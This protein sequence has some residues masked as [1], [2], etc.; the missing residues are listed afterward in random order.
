MARKPNAQSS[1]AEQELNKVEEQFE[2]FDEDVKELTLDRMRAAPKE[3]TEQQTKISQRDM[4]RT[5]DVYLKPKTTLFSKEKFNERFRDDYNFAKEYV[6]FIAENEEIKGDAMTVWTKPFPGCPAEEW[7]VPANKPVWG[8]RYLA[9][10]IN[11]CEYSRLEMDE[12][13]SAGGS[14]K[15]IQYMGQMVVDRKIARLKAIPVSNR[16]SVFMGASGF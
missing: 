2:K 1:L 10:Q 12:S 16:K 14:E 3:E 9:E 6:K 4:E 13:K 8:P 7:P 5:S 11:K 15:T